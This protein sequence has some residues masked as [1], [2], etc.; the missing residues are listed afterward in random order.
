MSA[1]WI[2]EA[3]TNAVVIDS[4]AYATEV[5]GWMDTTSSAINDDVFGF[6]STASDAINGTVVRFYND[7][8]S[9][10]RGALSGTVFADSVIEL[11]RCVIGNKILALSAGLTWLKA[12]MHVSLPRV[13][14][15][16]LQLKSISVME[17]ANPI[18]DAAARQSTDGGEA[19][20]VLGRIVRGYKTILKGEMILFGVFLGIW[21]LVVLSACT[22]LLWHRFRGGRKRPNPVAISKE[23]STGTGTPEMTEKKV[24]TA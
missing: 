12:N 1:N 3:I 18:G 19:R 11:L 9:G 14:P 6:A 4:V 10:I 24:E 20:G 21:L 7:L 22:I 2:A 5:N 23:D 16:F 17:M 8:E 15:A 13:D